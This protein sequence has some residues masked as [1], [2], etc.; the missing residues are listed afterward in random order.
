[1]DNMTESEKV[2]AFV[3][4]CIEEYKTLLGAEGRKVAD[5]FEKFGVTDY[6]IKN[7]DIL[8]TLSRDAIL[9]DIGK[10]IENR[11]RKG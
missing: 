8:H 4:F 1:M 10:F 11:S 3:S 6:L 9:D 2:L 7:Y 5:L